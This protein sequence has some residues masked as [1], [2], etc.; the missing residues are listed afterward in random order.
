MLRNLSKIYALYGKY[1]ADPSY[2]FKSVTVPKYKTMYLFEAKIIVLKKLPNTVTNEGRTG[3]IDHNF[4]QFR[5]DEFEVVEI[6]DKIDPEKTYEA[7]FNHIGHIGIN[8][9]L[10]KT[11]RY[12]KGKKVSANKF[13]TNLNKKYSFGIHYFKSISCAFFDGFSDFSTKLPKDKLGNFVDQFEY[14]FYSENGAI[15]SREMLP[16]G[17]CEY[18]HWDKSQKWYEHTTSKLDI[19]VGQAKS[20]HENGSEK[21]ICKF[22]EKPTEIGQINPSGRIDILL[23]STID[24]EFVE[25]YDCGQIKIV[26]TYVMG[27]RDG[28]WKIYFKNGELYCVTTFSNGIKK[29]HIKHSKEYMWFESDSPF[30]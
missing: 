23:Y 14:T 17:K 10:N 20:W 18:W 8:Y 7:T 4:A 25:K 28:E 13:D 1:F 27:L 26:G 12:E 19:I 16:F 2:V 29:S 6:F 11:L 5:G 30:L 9:T 3:V 22:S 15:V 24:G 21:V